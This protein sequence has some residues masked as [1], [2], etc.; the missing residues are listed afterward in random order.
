MES[1]GCRR[2]TN[3]EVVLADRQIWSSNWKNKCREDQLEKSFKTDLD[4]SL[5]SLP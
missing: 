2:D 5:S 3:N 1:V 4:P